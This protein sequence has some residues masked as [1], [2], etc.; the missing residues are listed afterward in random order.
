MA[1]PIPPLPT[2]SSFS[3]TSSAT[4][5]TSSD[6]SST[7]S[8]SSTEFSSS[9][10][11]RFHHPLPPRDPWSQHPA[12]D[13]DDE[14]VRIGI[15]GSCDACSDGMSR[16]HLRDGRGVVVVSGGGGGHDKN[17]FGPRLSVRWRLR[18]FRPCE[19]RLGCRVLHKHPRYLKGFSEW[20][21]L[22]AQRRMTEQEAMARPNQSYKKRVV[23]ITPK[24][25]V[26]FSER[27]CD[28]RPCTMRRNLSC[29]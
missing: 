29:Y 21:T 2:T 8:S 16:A 28:D 22:S 27:G 18:P 24:A 15:Y 1:Y 9:L 25:S 13:D 12:N 3:S 17:N 5:T 4:T 11:P 7:T 6:S 20:Q 10:D 14:G 26:L 19:K 23:F